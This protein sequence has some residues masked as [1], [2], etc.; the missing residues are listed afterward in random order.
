LFFFKLFNQ[1]LANPLFDAFFPSITDLHK[2]MWFVAGVFPFLLVLWF[3]KKRLQMLKIFFGMLISIGVSDTLCGQFLK[4]GIARPRPVNNQ[5]GHPVEVR[6]NTFSGYS[7]PSAH[8]TNNFTWANF[9]NQYYPQ[10]A[11]KYF[12]MAGLV[13]YSRVY[14]GVHYP[15]DIIAGGV[16]GLFL[17]WLMFQVYEYFCLNMMINIQLKRTRK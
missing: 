2:E 17:G 6:T 5:L 15:F 8:S 7:L 4:D 10:H 12:L 1:L 14:V 13:A 11:S 3:W 16:L 9:L